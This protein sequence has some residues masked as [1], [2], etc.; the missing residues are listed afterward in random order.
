MTPRAVVTALTASASA[1]SFF[2]WPSD[3]HCKITAVQVSAIHSIH[4]FLRFFIA[5]H[6]N[7]SEPARPAA[8]A[9]HHKVRFEDSTMRGESVLEI[10]F[11]GVEGEVPDKQFIIHAVVF[12][13]IAR[14][15]P[16]RSDHRV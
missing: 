13:R 4:G 10:V 9:I 7:E 11:R 14:G 3:V 6:G 2:A 15:F 16:E 1:R 8:G 12:L 5:A